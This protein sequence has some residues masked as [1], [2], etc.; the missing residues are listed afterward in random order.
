MQPYAGIALITLLLNDQ[1]LKT[2][3]PGTLTGKLSDFAGLILLPL[4]LVSLVELTIHRPASR[5]A[6]N[7]A[8]TFVGIGF[9]GV[10]TIT[11]IR[12]AYANT[13]GYL[14]WGLSFGQITQ[15]PIAI[16]QDATDL[17]T[18]PALIIAYW[19]VTLTDNPN[20]GKESDEMTCIIHHEGL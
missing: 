11:T 2:I 14:R 1:I 3:I 16:I 8:I 18:L 17:L 20:P 7:L 9:T 10:K 13:I 19:I 5:I 4:L 6:S 12:I 15:N